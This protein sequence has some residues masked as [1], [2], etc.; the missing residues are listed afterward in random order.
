MEKRKRTADADVSD[1]STFCSVRNSK[2]KTHCLEIHTLPK[3]L[4]LT[5]V[6]GGHTHAH[7]HICIFSVCLLQQ[8]PHY[9]F[10]FE[11]RRKEENNPRCTT[12]EEVL[13][14]CFTAVAAHLPLSSPT[15][16][17]IPQF[18]KCASSRF[19]FLFLVF[20]QGMCVGRCVRVLKKVENPAATSV[21]NEPPNNNDQ[22]PKS[23][24]TATLL[25]IYSPPPFSDAATLAL[26]DPPYRSTPFRKATNN[27]NS[28]ARR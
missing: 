8:C 19:F 7:T 28:L 2:K 27:G 5:A 22:Q 11:S 25:S 12:R 16:V 13:F 1:H 10:R 6:L 21:G 14:V 20:T 4:P 17:P 26:P 9:L 24:I 23:I 15:H 18:S 3:V